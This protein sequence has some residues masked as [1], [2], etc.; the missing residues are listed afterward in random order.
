MNVLIITPSFPNP[1]NLTEG[2]FNAQQAQALKKAANNVII[3]LCKPIIPEYLAKKL[4]RYEHL[5]HL[6]EYEERDGMWIIYNR[7][8]QIPHYAFLT[9]NRYSCAHS[10]IKTL[11]KRKLEKFSDVIQV[12]STYP[13]GLAAP[14]VSQASSCPYVL[15]LHI[16]DDPRLFRSHKNATLYKN[17]L[18]NASALITV[19]SPLN[20]FLNQCF[21]EQN[22]KI[23]RTIHN[24][25]DLSLI[26]DILKEMGEKNNRWGHIISISN[27]WP[28]K[29]ID[30]ILKA[31]AQLTD[32][33]VPWR[34]FTIIG[35]GPERKNL[36]KLADELKINDRVFFLGRLIHKDTLRELSLADIFCL[37]SHQESFGVVYLEAM[38][39][40]KPAIGCKGQGAE[41][42][43]RNGDDGLLV[44]P[45]DPASLA[46][47]LKRLIQD[48][49]FAV[50]LGENAKLRARQFT[51]KRNV[52]AYL[53]VYQS[54][55]NSRRL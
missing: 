20:R 10:I 29:G 23:C 31:L 2:L 32:E 12:H 17:M 33:R 15:T 50:R 3:I 14:I 4:K 37:P 27:L 13:T 22:Q 46:K 30:I 11:R 54:I 39:M 36:E 18:E 8:L 55:I 28:I 48:P 6:P 1:G 24:G 43:I 47:A 44:P 49:E 42:I 40:G 5:A 41:D 26:D 25:I 38:A 35:E 21:P 52:E 16:Q 19:G 53:E 9:L 34:R 45:K 7:F 51:W